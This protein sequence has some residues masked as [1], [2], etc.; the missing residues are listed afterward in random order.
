MSEGAEEVLAPLDPHEALVR[1]TLMAGGGVQVGERWENAVLL[2]AVVRQALAA[3]GEPVAW[4][5]E[6]E[7]RGVWERVSHPDF[8]KKEMEHFAEYVVRERWQR[9]ARVIPLGIIP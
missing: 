2:A 7:N 9:P 5:V 4:M 3:Q 1:L 8:S 6:A